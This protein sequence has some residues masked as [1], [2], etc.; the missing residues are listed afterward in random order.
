MTS[1]ASP[2]VLRIGFL[3][4]VLH[5]EPATAHDVESSFVLR[6]IFE[7]PFDVA[8]GST[9]VEP[10]LF[11]GPLQKRGDEYEAELR[12]DIFFSDG[13]RLTAEHLAASLNAAALLAS[14]AGV[15]A[16]GQRLVFSLARPNA[17]FDLALSHFDC[18]VQRRVGQRLLGTG[19]YVLAPD[20]TPTFVR[21]LRNPHHRPAP[22]IDEVHFLTY[23]PDPDARATALLKALEEGSVDLSLSLGRQDIEAARNV[24]K[25]ILPGASTAILFLNGDSPRLR[26]RRVR[27][28]LA[29]GL[30]RYEL[31]RSSYANPLAFA[32]SSLTPRQLGSVEDSLSYDPAR[33]QT[34][35]TAPGVEPPQK[36]DL[37][38]AW[39]PRPYLPYPQKVAGLVCE[40]LGRLGVSVKV[41]Q[42]PTSEEF[43][44]AATRGTHDLVLSGWVA[45]TLDPHDFLEALLSS[46]R[47]M[48][49]ENAAVACNLGRLRSAEMDAALARFRAVREAANVAAIT[50]VLAREAPLV[51]L[52]YGP[53]ASVHSY[54][55]R[56]VKPSPLW[57]VPAEKLDLDPA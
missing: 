26:D 49:P 33:A 10:R 15:R 21:L 7:A 4:P 39:A 37:L 50:D 36:L 35:L 48:R 29:H 28:A 56:H 53:A 51:P 24:R 31:A 18:S 3:T 1:S 11:R 54:R 2:K 17:R 34:L 52:M 6:H 43:T 55:V 47:I 8:Y 9:E 5:F 20:S 40:Q 16:K 27:Q 25:S 57:Y 30:D 44:R 19:P 32:A 12:D 41:H 13:E 38:L 42:P 22:A 45:D 23:P 46:E 14:Q